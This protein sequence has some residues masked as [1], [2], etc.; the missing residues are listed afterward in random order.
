MKTRKELVEMVIDTVSRWE[1]IE[2]VPHRF[3]GVE[4]QF[5]GKEV[6]HIHRSGMV[7][8]P[9][10]K[11]LREHLV[12]EEHTGLHHLL[13]DTGWTTFY[14]RHAEDVDK[15][16]WLFRISLLQKQWRAARYDAELQHALREEIE[17]RSAS[18]A[19]MT[20]IGVK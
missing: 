8:I 3:G 11:R 14:I 19:L 9:Y 20:A 1:Q 5:E 13:P 7:D 4:F 10:T 17:R 16:I 15:A 2:A 18:P 6:G 12:T